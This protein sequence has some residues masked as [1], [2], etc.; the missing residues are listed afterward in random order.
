M[1]NFALVRNDSS[2]EILNLTLAF[3]FCLSGSAEN[4]LSY[5]LLN[6]QPR[7]QGILL[8]LFRPAM[9]HSKTF[10]FLKSILAKKASVLFHA[11][12]FDIALLERFS[13]NFEKS[14]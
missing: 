6:V 7:L 12:Y 9:S 2:D 11:L 3:K 5:L 8:T 1:G 13:K 4:A 10:D 14:P